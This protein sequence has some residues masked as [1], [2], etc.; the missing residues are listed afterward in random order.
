MCVFKKVTLHAIETCQIYTKIVTTY[1]Y[2][3]C[4]GNKIVLLLPQLNISN[5]DTNYQII[6]K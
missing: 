4:G 2:K 1:S 5:L 6:N 3:L